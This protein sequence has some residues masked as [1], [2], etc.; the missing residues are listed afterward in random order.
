MIEGYNRFMSNDS[1]EKMKEED[2]HP[3]LSG[4]VGEW[5]GV[6]TVQFGAESPILT[7]K[8]SGT[9]RLMLDGRF[10]LHEYR[11]SVDGKPHSG[12]A[13]YG[14]NTAT[15]QFE[16]AWV[17]SFHNGDGIMFSKGE[18]GESFSV[19]GHY[20]IDLGNG[21]GEVSYGWRTMIEIVSKDKVIIRMDNLAPDGSK[22]GGAE[23]TYSRIR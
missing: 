9:M 22:D 14:Y 17:D 4:L 8:T 20:S 1:S 19:V 6:T 16:S 13:I 12:A 2:L 3:L 21:E 23:T 5:E 10:I 7:D 15:K 18:A 11:G